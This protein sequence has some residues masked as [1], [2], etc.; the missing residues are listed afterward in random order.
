MSNSISIGVVQGGPGLSCS[1]FNSLA[2][3]CNGFNSLIFHELIG[4]GT[5]NFGS[6][7]TFDET[8][9]D[10]EVWLNNVLNQGVTKF[11]CHSWGGLLFFATM[12]RLNRYEEIE[13]LS[14]WNVVPLDREKYDCVSNRLI[15]R[16]TPE[17]GAE[18]SR[19]LEANGDNAG[20]EI[21]RLAWQFYSPTAQAEPQVSFSYCPSTYNSVAATLGAFDYWQEFFKLSDRIQLV[22]G[23]QDYILA[24]DFKLSAQ[25]IADLQI[26]NG[27]HFPFVEDPVGMSKHIINWFS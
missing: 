13:R 27:G 22:F 26:V 21:M 11:L 12:A 6:S 25:K 3:A 16:V 23:K 5:N 4:C 19:L 24:D 2:T 18:M 9:S 14:L 7:P 20:D 8:I 10:F 1:Y 17:A 15:A